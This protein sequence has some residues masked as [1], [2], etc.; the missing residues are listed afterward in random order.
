[1]RAPGANLYGRGFDQMYVH[2]H[3]TN[4]KPSGSLYSHV[5]IMDDGLTVA[6]DH[7]VLLAPQTDGY[8]EYG[9]GE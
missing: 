2:P 5:Q 4:R 6:F 3:F 8:K 1:M 9:Y 7:G